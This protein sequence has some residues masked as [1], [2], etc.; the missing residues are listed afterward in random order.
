LGNSMERCPRNCTVT[1]PFLKAEFKFCSVVNVVASLSFALY[2]VKNA[3]L[4]SVVNVGTNG[5][6]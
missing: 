1:D 5:K 3:S 6:G 2:G 4:E